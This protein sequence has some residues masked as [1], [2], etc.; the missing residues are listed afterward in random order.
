MTL[1]A[2]LIGIGLILCLGIVH[3][4]GVL[5]IIRITPHAEANGHVAVLVTFAGLFAL[6]LVEIFAFALV[7]A[8]LLTFDSLGN[9]GGSYS[10]SWADLI[11]FSGT[12]F[13]TLGY[14]DITVTGP[15]RIINMM[16]SLGGF[17]ALTWSATLIY[18]VSGTA[19]HQGGYTSRASP[20]NA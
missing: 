10:G 4:F 16:Q 3:H 8:A 15:I 1:F 19:W 17:M 12:N 20:E 2:L 13:V 11:Y 6:H 9:F 18:S 5:T 7:F 14:T